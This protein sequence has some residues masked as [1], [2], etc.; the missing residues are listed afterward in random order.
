MGQQGGDVNIWHWKADWQAAV[1]AQQTAPENTSGQGGA[2]L[3][4][5]C[6]TF[7]TNILFTASS[8]N[9]ANN[10][11]LASYADVDSCQAERPAT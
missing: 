11:I 1:I 10:V 2:R 4:A 9:A 3:L 6:P 8:D 5:T 7:M